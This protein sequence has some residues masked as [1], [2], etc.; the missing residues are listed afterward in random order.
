MAENFCSQLQSRNRI[1]GRTGT[2]F[3][4]KTKSNMRMI[5]VECMRN[6]LML[7]VL[8][9]ERRVVKLA[10]L[11]SSPSELNTH[12]WVN[13][14]MNTRNITEMKKDIYFCYGCSHKK[15]IKGNPSATLMI[16]RPCLLLV[17][18]VVVTF[19]NSFTFSKFSTL[20]S[21]KLIRLLN[22]LTLYLIL[23][24]SLR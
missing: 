23:R 4:T 13:G 24:N 7:P 14:D 20:W 6:T 21:L 8:Q 22:Y 2:S 10:S 9:P 16:S 3:K 17:I 11:L 1:S 18:Y 19:H 5:Y 15:R 12:L